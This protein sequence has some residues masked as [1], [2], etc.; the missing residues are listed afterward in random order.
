MHAVTDVWEVRFA[1]YPFDI[2]EFIRKNV[3]VHGGK[4]ADKVKED[5][6]AAPQIFFN[7][8]DMIDG[9]VAVNIVIEAADAQLAKGLCS[10]EL[11]LDAIK[12]VRRFLDVPR[13]RDL[14]ARLK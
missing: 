8:E 3:D 12:G 9:E 11:A 5:I 6:D 13:V 7:E 1:A 10:A 2:V 4:L 14:S